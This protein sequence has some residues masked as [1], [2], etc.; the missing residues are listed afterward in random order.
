MM[1]EEKKKGHVFIQTTKGIYAYD[2]LAKAKKENTK[3][4]KEAQK[5]TS[6]MGLIDPPFSPTA[7]LVLLESNVVFARCVKQIAIDVAGLGWS[8]QLKEGK[9]DN[10]AELE[11]IEAFLK[12]PNPTNTFRNTLKKL[13]V[14]YGSIGWFGL[15]VIRDKVDQ[16]LEVYHVPAHTIKVHKDKDKYCQVRGTKKIWFKKFG[17]DQNIAAADGKEVSG[18]QDVANEM[19]FYKNYYPRSDYYGVPDVLPAVGDVIGAINQ[20]DYNLA[21]FQNFGMPSAIIIL[22]GDWDEGSEGAVKNFV[23]N[24]HTG[25]ENAHKT[26]VVSQPENVKFTYTPLSGDA[27]QDASFKLYEQERRNNIMIAYSMPPERIGV[28]LVGKLGGNVAEEATKIY[29]EGVVEPLQQDIEEMINEKLLQSEIYEFKFNDIDLRNYTAA[30]EQHT[31]MVSNAMETP[32]EAR[33]EL[34]MGEPYS[35]GDK[36]YVGTSLITVG[37]PSELLSKEEQELLDD[38]M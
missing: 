16:V 24:S 5:Y 35:E 1:T 10:V 23:K 11:R 8:M 37:E 36:F 27:P 31:A 4:L 17:S 6:Q 9:K 21:F 32:N 28:R 30:I 33:K 38:V 29:V 25:T 13:I 20:R 15:E 19:I 34:G 2:L 22:E 7:F 26:L 3:Q 12:H 14:D 18:D